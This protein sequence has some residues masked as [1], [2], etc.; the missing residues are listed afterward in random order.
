MTNAQSK[1]NNDDESVGEWIFG[2]CYYNATRN[3]TRY[4][5]DKRLKVVYGSLG[6]N[7]HFEYGGRNWTAK[8]F[9]PNPMDSHAW[10]EDAEGNVYDYIFPEYAAFAEK[11]GKT[12]TFQSDWEILG[13]SKA[14]LLEDG[15]E[16]I[17]APRKAQKDILKNVKAYYY[18]SFKVNGDLDPVRFDDV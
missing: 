18:K 8:E 7:G 9:Y 16:Y 11:W 4:F 5:K 17:P 1:L 15:L 3:N 10:L 13:L 2:H 12:V 14:D 6:L